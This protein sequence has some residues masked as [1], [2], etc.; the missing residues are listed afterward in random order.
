MIRFLI[1]YLIFFITS[2]NK[3]KSVLICGDHVCINNDEARQYFEENLSIEV[4]VVDKQKNKQIDLVEL[5]LKESN[6]NKKEVLLIRKNKPNKTIKALSKIETDSIRSK[7]KKKK[8]L[9]KIAKKNSKDKVGKLKVTTETIPK[10]NNQKYINK[11][12]ENIIDVC[13][14]IE[15][16]NIEEISKYLIKQGKKRGFP[17]ITIRE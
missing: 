7:I 9:K 2:C 12:K 11:T 6:N 5:N 17:D 8:E 4:K 1:I 16:C 3:P 13:T 10:K 14:I 15:Q